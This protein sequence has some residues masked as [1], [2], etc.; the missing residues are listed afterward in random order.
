LGCNTVADPD[1]Y[2]CLTA[3]IGFAA[4][5][6]ARLSAA[7]VRFWRARTSRRIRGTE[8]PE[9]ECGGNHDYTRR[10]GKRARDVSV[11]DMAA[12]VIG[13][14]AGSSIGVLIYGIFAGLLPSV[15]SS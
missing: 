3:K 12:N 8:P 13:I 7:W 5:P 6:A 10:A 11:H 1:G 15:R 9:R 14:A 2:W 4:E